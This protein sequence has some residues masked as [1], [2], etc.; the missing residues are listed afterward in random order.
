MKGVQEGGGGDLCG[1]LHRVLHCVGPAMGQTRAGGVVR[2]PACHGWRRACPRRARCGC[3]RSARGGVLLLVGG[4]RWYGS[5]QK[6]GVA[7][8]KQRCVVVVVA[9]KREMHCSGQSSE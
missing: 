4:V 1:G 7:C 3:M 5:K 9:D 8:N 6:G 2:Q